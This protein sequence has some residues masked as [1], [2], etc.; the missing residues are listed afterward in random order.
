MKGLILQRA[1]L[2]GRQR[3]LDDDELGVSVHVGDGGG[4]VSGQTLTVNAAF[5]DPGVL[6]THTATINFGSGPQTAT[7]NESSGSG[8]VTGSQLYTLPGTYMV[9]VCVSDNESPAVCDSLSLTVNPFPVTIDI[10]P[11]AFPNTIVLRS[12]GNVQVA[13]FG[14]PTFNVT[15]IVPATVTFAGAPIRVKNNGSLDYN[16]QDINF[17][18]LPD[19]VAKFNIEALQ[20]TPGATQ[21]ELLGR[22]TSGVYIRGID[23]VQV[24]P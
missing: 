16:I 8:T 9:T 19:M 17:D 21:A 3:I 20:L 24:L 18:G 15:T 22:A 2:F 6:D 5:T 1:A 13:I 4:V 14:S 7:V 10:K 23:S 11:G 12:N